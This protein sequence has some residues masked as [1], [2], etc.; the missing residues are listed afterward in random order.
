MVGTKIIKPLLKGL[1][2]FYQIFLSF[3]LGRACRFSPTCS[4]YALEAL[5]KLSL[6][7]ALKVSA[8]RILRC[9]PGCKSGFDP[10]LAPEMEA[11]PIELQNLPSTR[12]RCRI[13]SLKS[14]FRFFYNAKSKA[15]KV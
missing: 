8:K 12:V 6:A 9:R 10:V 11:Q 3:F 1:I 4:N 13:K 7:Q 15:L 2:Y 14:R 5:E